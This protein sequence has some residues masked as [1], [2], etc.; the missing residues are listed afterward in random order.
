MENPILNSSNDLTT[1]SAIG[2]TR[3]TLNGLPLGEVAGEVALKTMGVSTPTKGAANVS[4]GHV[5]AGSAATLVVARP[6][7]RSVLIR[8]T[9]AT[10]SVYIGPATVSSSN[11]MLL[12]AGEAVAVSW[13]GLIQVV[14]AAN[15]PVVAFFDEYD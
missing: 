14:A 5:T 7:R 11:G 1:A 15:T 10:D 8:N 13:V 4:V 3:K 6:T 12:K 9:D 2:A